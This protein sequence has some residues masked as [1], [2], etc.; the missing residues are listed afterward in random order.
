MRLLVF[1]L[2]ITSSWGN[3]HATVY[4][5][6]LKE[7]HRQRV[8]VTFVEKDVPWY[9]ENR[10]LPRTDFAR[11]LL[12][13][14]AGQLEDL[15]ATEIPRSDVVLMGSYFPDGVTVATRLANHGDLVRLYYDIDTPVTLAAFAATGA[16]PYLESE[17]LAVFDAVLSFT[18]GRA[19][20]ELEKR[21]GA[22][23]TVAFYCA[24]DP[25]THYRVE[26]VETFR[27]RLGY[28]GTY[29]ADRQ[30]AMARL[31][32]RPALGLPQ[33]RFV[34]AGP[35]YPDMALPPNVSHFHHLPP[36]MHSAF[37]SSC[38]LTLNITRGPMVVYGYSPSVRLFE[39]A[40]CG[41][42]VIS[43]RWDGLEELFE[44]GKEILVADD[45]ES[46]LALLRET[47]PEAAME[48]GERFRARALREHT[49][50]V[51]ARQF[52]DLVRDL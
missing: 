20:A 39:A 27:C 19:L 29:S 37:Y 38:D 28:M 40:G 9:A 15:L 24:L 1:G 6:L 26:P 25:E 52:L 48:L 11:I 32:L 5:G 14:G 41:A 23:R 42:C 44:V 7:L 49:F 12:Y 33:Q 10:D 21:W 2:S 13:R 43:D 18:G 3:G 47:T 46:M 31:F 17:Q 51:R 30:E 22:R 16:T 8:D 34:L 36:G 45:T 35:Q 50:A 4:R